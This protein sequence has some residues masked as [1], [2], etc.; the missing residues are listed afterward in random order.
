MRVA[1]KTLAWRAGKPPRGLAARGIRIGLALL[2]AVLGTQAAAQQAIV[3]TVDGAVLDLDFGVRLD[4]GS[5]PAPEAFTV[6][7]DGRAWPTPASVEVGVVADSIVRLTLTVPVGPRLAATV[8]YAPPAADALQT[9]DGDPLPAR[10]DIPVANARFDVSRI[11]YSNWF[12]TYHDGRA[13]SSATISPSV[14]A[15]AAP[16][17]TGSRPTGYDVRLYWFI[18][19]TSSVTG[20]DLFVFPATTTPVASP[21]ERVDLIPLGVESPSGNEWWWSQQGLTWLAPNTKYALALETELTYFVH[22]EPR[23]VQRAAEGWTG[24]E[25]VF[26][27]D[28]GE[29]DDDWRRRGYG[30]EGGGPVEL[31]IEATST[32]IGAQNMTVARRDTGG[33]KRRGASFRDG[34]GELTLVDLDFMGEDFTNV[35]S[36]FAAEDGVTLRMLWVREFDASRPNDVVVEFAGA[37]LPLDDATQTDDTAIDRTYFWDQDWL[38]LNAPWLNEHAY[39]D[40]LPVGR[41]APTCLRMIEEHCPEHAPQAALSALTLSDA[42]G[43]PVD[44]DMTF[45]PETTSYVAVLPA[46]APWVTIGGTVA[47]DYGTLIL[48]DADGMP[49]PDADTN[50]AGHQVALQPGANPITARVF[51]DGIERVYTLALWRR[52]ASTKLAGLSLADADGNPVDLTPS[53]NSKI[54]AYTASVP[55][56]TDRVT[57]TAT[58]TAN[59]AIMDDDDPATPKEAAL[60]LAP[61]RSVL[62]VTATAPGVATTTYTVTVTRALLTGLLV[63]DSSG[64]VP[65]TPRF[66]ATTTAYRALSNESQVSISPTPTSAA[67][68]VTYLDEQDQEID[69]ASTDAGFQVAL[70]PVRTVVKVRARTADGDQETRI[71]TLGLEATVDGRILDLDF[72]VPLDAS[73]VPDAD[74]FSVTGDGREWPVGLVTMHGTIAR[75]TLVYQVGPKLAATVSYTPPAT[76]ALQT[77]AGVAV[78]ALSD[79]PVVNAR[80]APS[81]ILFTNRF[82]E[83]L[84]GRELRPAETPAPSEDSYARFAAPFTT[85]PRPTGYPAQ[86]TFRQHDP[87]FVGQSTYLA[88]LSDTASLTA[89]STSTLPTVSNRGQPTPVSGSDAAGYTTDEVWLQPNAT[90]ALHVDP[91]TGPVGY[92]AYYREPASRLAKAGWR[93]ADFVFTSDLTGTD[94]VWDWRRSD[95]YDGGQVELHIEASPQPAFSRN[96][97]VGQGTCGSD[98]CRGFFDDG[99]IGTLQSGFGFFSSVLSAPSSHV[100]AL[101]V[102]A[103]GV[104]LIV[105]W[106]SDFDATARN[107][108]VLEFAGAWLSL[109][110]ARSNDTPKGRLYVWQQGWLDLNAPWLN[111]DNYENTLPAGRSAPTCL[112]FVEAHC[113]S[114]TPSARLSA[115]ELSDADGNPIALDMTFDP[116]TSAYKATVAAGVDRV[117]VAGAPVAGFGTLLLLDADGMP[118]PDADPDTAGHQVALKDGATT[119]PGVCSGYCVVV[120]VIVDGSQRTYILDLIRTPHTRLTGLSLV[121]ANGNPVQLTPSFAST[122]TA[123]TAS[124]PGA[125]DQVTLTATTTIADV[126]IAI[127]NDDAPATPYEA[128]LDLPQRKTTLSVTVAAPDSTSTTYTVRVTRQVLDLEATVDGAVL[129]LDF[130]V[131]LDAALVPAPA[132]FAVSGDGRPWPT[133]AAVEVDGSIMRLSLTVPVGPKLAATVSY[134]P[135]AVDA[136]HTAVGALVN[137]LYEEPVANARFDVSPI[138]YSNWFTSFLGGLATTSAT[139]SHGVGAFAAPFTTGSRPT[140]YDVRLYWFMEL[141]SS[142]SPDLFVFPATTTPVASP[143]ERVGLIPVVASRAPNSWWST[144]KEKW[145][146]PNTTYAL[147]LEADGLIYFVHEEPRGVQRAAEGWTG[148]E[149]VFTF[150]EDEGVDDWRLRGYGEVGG[151]PVEL[152]IEAASTPIGAQN[153]TVARRDRGGLKRRGASFRDNWGELTL[154][155]LDFMGEEFTNVV[156]LFAAEDGVTLRMLWVREFDA[157]RR[158]DVVVEFAGAWLPLD[159]AT[160]DADGSLAVNYIWDQDYLDLNAPWLNEQAYIDTLPVDRLA[161]TCLRMI[162]EHC[163]EYLPDATLSAL[164]VTD[165]DGNPLAL[166]MTFDPATTDYAVTIPADVRSVTVGGTF[167]AGFGTL[168][169]FDADGMAI[170]D[171]D[172]VAEGHQVYFGG[173]EAVVQ[174]RVLVDGVERTYTLRLYRA[175]AARLAGLALADVRG[176]PIALAP[177]FAS[178]TT[179]YTASVPY[180][181][182]QVTLTAS[183]TSAVVVVDI[184]GDDDPATPAEAVFQLPEDTTTTVTVTATVVDV[185]STVYTVAV[186]RPA[187]PDLSDCPIW[188]ATVTATSTYGGSFIGYHSGEGGEIDNANFVYDGKGYLVAQVSHCTSSPLLSCGA[189][190]DVYQFLVFPVPAFDF[191]LVMGGQE[192]RS[193]N[194][195]TSTAQMAGRSDGVAY[196]WPRG[197]GDTWSAGD[198]FDVGMREDPATAPLPSEPLAVVTIAPSATTPVL[199]GEYVD[200]EFELTRNV[201][202]AEQ[203]VWVELE[204]TRNFLLA[205]STDKLWRRVTFPAAATSTTLGLQ[206]WTLAEF[207]VGETVEGGTITARVADAPGYEVGA[208]DAAQRD[209]MVFVAGFDDA[210]H[211]VDEDAGSVTA[212]FTG[213]FLGGVPCRTEARNYFVSLSTELSREAATS[214]RAT[215]DEDYL[216][217]STTVILEIPIGDAECMATSS[218]TVAI[219]WDAEPEETEEFWLTLDASAGSRHTTVLVDPDG[220]RVISPSLP[221]EDATAAQIGASVVRIIDVP[222][223]GIESVA[224]DSS[225]ALA[226]DTY[227][228]G[229]IIAVAVRFSDNVSPQLPTQASTIELTMQVGSGDRELEY[230]HQTVTDTLLFLYEVQPGDRDNDGVAFPLRLPFAG[231]DTRLELALLN[232]AEIVGDDDGNPVYPFARIRHFPGASNTFPDHKVDGTRTTTGVLVSNKNEAPQT[233]VRRG[234]IHAQRFES[235]TVADPAPGDVW[236]LHSIAGAGRRLRGGLHAGG[237]THPRGERGR[238]TGRAGGGAALAAVGLDEHAVRGVPGVGGRRPRSGDVLLRRL[239]RP[240]AVPVERADVALGRRDRAD[241]PR[242]VDRR[243]ARPPVGPGGRLG[244]RGEQ[245][246][247]ADGSPRLRDDHAERTGRRQAAH[248]RPGAA[249]GRRADGGP[250]PDHRSQRHGGCGVGVPVAARRGV[251]QRRDGADLHAG[252]RR[253]RPAPAGAGQLYRRRRLP[254]DADEHRDAVRGGGGPGGRGADGSAD[255]RRDD[256]PGGR[257]ADGG[258]VRRHGRRRADTGDVRLHVGRRPHR[259][260]ARRRPGVQPQSRGRGPDS[261]AAVDLHGRR[262]D[263][264][265]AGEHGDDGGG[266]AAGGRLH[267]GHDRAGRRR[268]DGRGRRPLLPQQRVAVRVP[269]PVGRRRCTGGVHAGRLPGGDRAYAQ[270]DVHERRR[271]RF[272]AGQRRLHRYGGDAGAVRAR[273]LGRSQL[274]RVE[275]SCRGALRDGRRGD[276]QDAGGDRRGR[277]EPAADAGVQPGGDE[278]CDGDDV[279]GGDGDGHRDRRRRGRDGDDR[280]HRRNHGYR[281]HRLRRQCDHRHG[282]RRRRRRGD[283]RA[284]RDAAVAAGAEPAGDGRPLP[285]RHAAR[286]RRPGGAG[287]GDDH[288]RRRSAGR[289]RLHVCLVSLRAG[290]ELRPGAAVGH[291]AHRHRRDDDGCADGRRPGQADRIRGELHRRRRFPRGGLRN[292]HAADRPGRRGRHGHAGHQCLCRPEH[293]HRDPHRRRRPGAVLHHGV[294]PWRLCA[295]KRRHRPAAGGVGHFGRHIRHR[296]G[297]NADDVES[298]PGQ[299]RQFRGGDQYLH[300]AGECRAERRHHLCSGRRGGVG[301]SLRQHLVA[302]RGG[303]TGVE[304]QRLPVQEADRV[305]EGR[306]QVAPHRGQGHGRDLHRRHPARSG[307]ADIGQ[308]PDRHHAVV[309]RDDDELRGIARRRPR[310]GHR[311]RNHQRRRRD[312]RGPR[313]RQRGRRRP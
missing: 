306:F 148:E 285:A 40:T 82:T 313:R 87:D 135:P 113:P 50:T 75:V 173:D 150:D 277:R 237:G 270:F 67:V 153:M 156:S 222:R 268:R 78:A 239:R 217:N 123:Y 182:E 162:E 21:E 312:R 213:R 216:A 27:Y 174:V 167:A 266:G 310:R 247:A 65:L 163:P 211:A 56:T 84:L 260:R 164:A 4:A 108:L 6:W 264:V 235:G 28:I 242:L 26:T 38:D 218:T 255:H 193:A 16:F 273:G 103:D 112:R 258:P 12:T 134:M 244:R 122:T 143:E 110:D 63:S 250:E 177:A 57:L 1:S 256:R 155:D 191:V 149:Y 210:Q 77:N 33:L 129:E 137:S 152:H 32:P 160:R 275:T 23:G 22:H 175:Q 212:T 102:T 161:P 144:E 243:Q 234:T 100:E 184:A 136:L 245:Q 251:H 29:G 116:A 125:T 214:T 93:L 233:N 261:Q 48:F 209:I 195:A 226:V 252:G 140:G 128:V 259:G 278:L 104:T 141:P 35:V 41:L 238:R 17:T 219:V 18:E 138:M 171:A 127:A 279:R 301:A 272:L 126:A 2:L 198:T 139:M 7:G 189:V 281:R 230:S 265:H 37:W 62:T 246:R 147:A 151:G 188:C 282:D 49:I 19:T 61:G 289:G 142:P 202:G 286:G 295:L 91:E 165:G 55:G 70:A 187:A 200:I 304:H 280:R 229:E 168:I 192:L 115:L 170:P 305:A 79:A 73:S 299:S 176:N 206:A 169:L 231:S 111:A 296:R 203:V 94:D 59:V 248:P 276:A 106:T 267:S 88:T 71:V 9:T 51:V 290:T 269:R 80:F 121:D 224:I 31:H 263:V 13:T 10:S 119:I 96:M 105:N 215:V 8:S 254:G 101:Y 157:S 68:T 190:D 221:F 109:D 181:L 3:A 92:F 303:R 172:S 118:I 205:D 183:T 223:T 30:D 253:R 292:D 34:W 145:L 42:D 207:E 262:G 271:R 227:G 257:H 99:S 284:D 166:D 114:H 283:V 43:N 208:A 158:N 204:Q 44:L 20:A 287:P 95:T 85:G 133:P 39:I 307:P 58:S 117:T 5:V 197:M 300:G 179:A 132:A 249:R 47:G 81:P 293:G 72:G 54:T 66:N 86:L 15:F 24:E 294:E 36:L 302:R 228:A 124:V 60:N 90:Y 131:P 107:D 236:R 274:H 178:S 201:A 146:A 308:P 196:V 120:R 25:Y 186:S 52:V 309:R 159:D 14:G 311:L 45:D 240:G 98:A 97:T 298:R 291:R 180:F 11:M 83:Q 154:V 53:F 76:E 69:D 185:G 288:G 232:G 241:R 194:A 199:Y 46:D 89:I 297:R 225:P 74:A 220:N 64:D 130:G